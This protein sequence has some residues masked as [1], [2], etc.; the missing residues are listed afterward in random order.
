M[1]KTLSLVFI[2]TIFFSIIALGNGCSDN[3]SRANDVDNLKGFQDDDDKEIIVRLEGADYGYP[4]PFTHY[5]RG[6]GRSKMRLIFDSLLERGEKGHIPWLAE[7][8]EISRE[9]KEYTFH[10]RKGVTWQDGKELTAEDVGFSFEYYLEHPPVDNEPMVFEILEKVEVLDKYRVKMTLT[11]PHAPFVLEAGELRIIP[12]H[13]WEEVEDPRKFTEEKSLTGTGPYQLTSYSEEHGTYEFKAWENFWGPNQKVDLIQ[14]KPVSD[15]VMALENKDIDLAEIPRDVLPRFENNPSHEIVEKP[16]LWAYRLIPNMERVSWLKEQKVR[17]AL[18]YAID[19]EKIVNTAGRGEGIPGN[20][21]LL[22]PDHYM[23]N[24]EVYSYEYNP[25]KARELLE[26]ARVFSKG[27]EV[28]LD[29][30]TGDDSRE[31]RIAELLRE[32][33]A[34][35]GIDLN[36]QAVDSQRRDTQVQEGN[37]QMAMIGHGGWGN[38]PNDYFLRRFEAQ[39][40][41]A[42]L[43]YGIP[44]YENKEVSRIGEEQSKEPDENKRREL[45]YEVQEIWAKDVP[46]I[47]LYYLTGHYV[48]NQEAYNGWTFVYNHHSLDQH[49]ISYLDRNHEIFREDR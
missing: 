32:D 30:L 17:Q 45:I 39:E 21:G 29:L 43:H 31:I 44:G 1:K 23:Y 36:I 41:G 49:K 40:E 33:L 10:I 5:A 13:I 8:W 7:D 4:Q 11:K 14:F 27:D 47:P 26:E 37:Y 48:Y 2:I 34:I 18:A 38:D 28:S 35:I 12:K 19:R 15:E 25:D 3:Q 46:E 20:M 9:G 22:P 6:P 24:P 16:G 42:G